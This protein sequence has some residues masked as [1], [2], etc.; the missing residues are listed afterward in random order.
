LIVKTHALY[1]SPLLTV[2]LGNVATYS[3]RPPV[4]SA[5]MEWMYVFESSNNFTLD[6]PFTLTIVIM[7]PVLWFNPCTVVMTLNISFFTVSGEIVC[8]RISGVVLSIG[9]AISPSND[10]DRNAKVVFFC[11]ISA[12]D[13]INEQWFKYIS[14]QI[15]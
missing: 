2:I 13:N 1:T 3:I 9:V 15:S 14:A 4:P 5:F 7:S 8:A 10:T 6:S 11:L 12:V